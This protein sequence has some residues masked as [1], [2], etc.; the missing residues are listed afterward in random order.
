[1]AEQ[2][3]CDPLSCRTGCCDGTV[4]RLGAN[5]KTKCGSAGR[6]CQACLGN[7]VNHVCAGQCTATNCPTGCCTGN[8]C[9]PADRLACA[10]DAARLCAVCDPAVADSCGPL[11]CQCG[12]AAACVTPR[13][14]VSNACVP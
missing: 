5:Q 7:C 14:C 10:G 9:V 4:C 11:G 6:P 13:T 1:M 2:C 12:G 8:D 3:I